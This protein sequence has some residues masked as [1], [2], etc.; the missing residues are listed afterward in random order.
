MSVIIT[1]ALTASVTSFSLDV[2]DSIKSNLTFGITCGDYAG[3]FTRIAKKTREIIAHYE[4]GAVLWH[5]AFLKDTLIYKGSISGV[6]LQ[7][8]AY[9]RV[10]DA[11]KPIVFK[12]CESL[13]PVI[14]SGVI[15]MTNGSKTATITYSADGCTTKVVI[16]RNGKTKEIERKINRKY[17]KWW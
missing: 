5:Q 15:T 17:K 16:E 12:R 1:P 9:S 7:D 14:S 11:D 13:V 6:N 8:S 2:L 4:K 10:I 3:S